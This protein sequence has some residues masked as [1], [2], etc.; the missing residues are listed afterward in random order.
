MSKNR[1]T[2]KQDYNISDRHKERHI[3][4]NELDLKNR[5]NDNKEKSKI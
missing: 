3:N 2:D 4:K 1:E 5:R